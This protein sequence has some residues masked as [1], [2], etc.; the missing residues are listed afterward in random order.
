MLC[1]SWKSGRYY[2]VD[3]EDIKLGSFIA[4]LMAQ[5]NAGLMSFYTK[6]YIYWI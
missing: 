3:G 6:V 2:V 5:V 1:L 4:G